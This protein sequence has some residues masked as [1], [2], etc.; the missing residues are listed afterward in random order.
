MGLKLL[1]FR[2]NECFPTLFIFEPQVLLHL[3]LLYS[4]GGDQLTAEQAAKSLGW[5]CYMVTALIQEKQI[6][7]F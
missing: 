5:V 7:A 2:N 1:V 4:P 3:L 6:F